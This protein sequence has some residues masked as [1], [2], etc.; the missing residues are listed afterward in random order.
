[1]FGDRPLAHHV[2]DAA[3]IPI[4]QKYP[5]VTKNARPRDLADQN[6]G[7]AGVIA[8]SEAINYPLLTRR[9]PENLEEIGHRKARVAHH[10]ESKMGYDIFGNPMPDRAI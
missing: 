3:L 1:M 6:T 4:W 7:K 5:R 8:R 2:K 9:G 10:P